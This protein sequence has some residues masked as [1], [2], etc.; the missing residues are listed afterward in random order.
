MLSRSR[1]FTS[2][3]ADQPYD[4]KLSEA[5]R[6]ARGHRGWSQS[7]LAKKVGVSAKSISLYE[8]NLNK[9]S[10]TTLQRIVKSLEFRILLLPAEYPVPLST[11]CMGILRRMRPDI[12]ELLD[13]LA[14]LDRSVD[15]AWSDSHRT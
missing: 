13:I 7:D 3:L 6:S 8:R 2:G 12:K 1:K 9:P 11:E 4:L 15:K 5:L 10:W 14:K